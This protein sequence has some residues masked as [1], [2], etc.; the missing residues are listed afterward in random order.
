M[1]KLLSL[2]AVVSTAMAAYAQQETDT[3]IVSLGKTSQIIFT[4]ED[5]SDVA[6]LRNYNFQQ[7]FDDILTRL[8]GDSTMAEQE[9][10]P[11]EDSWPDSNK[12]S[13]D[14]DH[15]YKEK[16]RSNF[17]RTRQS[18]NLDFGINNYLD[19]DHQLPDASLNH[20]VRPWGSWYVAINSLQR[21]RMANHFFVEWGFGV[22]WYN[23]KF[24]NDQ[25]S[26]VRNDDQVEF[27]TTAVVPG[28]DYAKSKLRVTHIN[29]SLVPVIDFNDRGSKPRMWS[30]RNKAFRFGIGPYVGYKIGSKTKR[31]YREEDG[32]LKKEKVRD[33]YYL[34]DFRYGVRAQVGFRSTDFFVNYD[35]N[36]VFKPDRG[37]KLNAITF[38]IIF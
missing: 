16:R 11:E 32:D 9:H 7:L 37:P 31:V 2:A 28:Y 13:D 36:E 20:A 34:N 14:D 6:I 25:T 3:V 15:Q 19:A 27:I 8:D 12:E 35:L 33:G 26:L 38:G 24:E 1:K 4:M 30:D 22:S 5:R 23:F 29:F 18:T 17:G 10:A 21:T